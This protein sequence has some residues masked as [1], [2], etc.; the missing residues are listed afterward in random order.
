MKKTVVQIFFFSFYTFLLLTLLQ[1]LPLHLIPGMEVSSSE[2]VEMEPHHPA[3]HSSTAVHS[4][5]NVWGDR[6]TT[7]MKWQPLTTGRNRD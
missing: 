6:A 4:D 2:W 5:M 1:F 3:T 7:F